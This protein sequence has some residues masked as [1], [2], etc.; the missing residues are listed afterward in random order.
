MV[1]VWTAMVTRS[2]A[3]TL[4]NRFVMFRNSSIQL[5]LLHRVGN[6]DLTADNFL[7]CCFDGLDCCRRDQIFVVLIDGI[8]DAVVLKAVSVNTANGAVLDTISNNLVDGV[9]DALDH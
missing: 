3:R 4:P 1:P 7:P 2:L 5:S 9:I 6:L 8:A